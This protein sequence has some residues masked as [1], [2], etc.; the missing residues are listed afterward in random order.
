MWEKM[1]KCPVKNKEREIA[2][3]DIINYYRPTVN[4]QWYWFMN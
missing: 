3:W 2:S 4:G 1:P